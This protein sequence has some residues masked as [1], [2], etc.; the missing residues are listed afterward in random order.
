MERLLPEPDSLFSK[1]LKTMKRNILTILAAAI[2]SCSLACIDTY[3]QYVPTP[4]TISAEKVQYEGKVYYSHVVKERQTLYGISKAYGVSIEEIYAAN[5]GLEQLGLQKDSYIRI[6]CNEASDNAVK[7]A[8]E[9]AATQIQETA[10]SVPEPTVTATIE[11][12]APKKGVTTHKVKWYEDLDGIAAK[13]GVSAEA[14]MKANGLSSKDL[15][16]KK[17]LIIPS[18]QEAESLTADAAEATEPA[19]D[20]TEEPQIEE[21]YP[22]EETAGYGYERKNSV[23]IRFMLPL[24]SSVGGSE[25]NMDFYCGALLAV[26]DKADEG[27]DVV[28]NTNDVTAGIPEMS[29]SDLA[30]TDVII[31]P[32]SPAQIQTLM[33]KIP[34]DLYVV[35][36]LDPKAESLCGKY[37]NLIQAPTPSSVQRMDVINW[38]KDDMGSHDKAIVFYEKYTKEL[39]DSS[40]INLLLA[41]SGLRHD[42]FSY[43]IL[44]GRNIQT[45]LSQLMTKEGVNRIIIASEKEAFVNDV[46]R[47][48]NLMIFNQ[49]Q[50]ML[51]SPA[52]IRGFETIEVDNL[53]NANLHVSAT[54]NVDYD[55]PRVQSFLMRYRALYG[56]EPTAFAFQG[57]DLSYY[58]ISLVSKWGD[59]WE[60]MICNDGRSSMLQEDFDFRRAP[61][62]G[63]CINRAVRHFI[64]G[65]DYSIKP[66]AK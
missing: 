54:Y 27:I 63:A 52:K 32:V 18:A 25:S 65:D 38:V 41:Q 66:A 28:V 34:E 45:A 8:T 9:T 33:A 62:G 46:V 51:Y 7:A 50:V 1:A 5:P 17:K 19:K 55:D 47:N 35:S 30:S 64:Y 13:Y 11:T 48:L 22:Q 24:K 59:N 61:D 43:S 37:H 26:K 14:I 12:P 23:N 15:S 3:A 44:E 40:S 42:K 58:F 29:S 31:G 56:T 10:Q 4:V 2:V 21:Q 6:P 49:Y 16:S 20:E 39:Q 60:E 53:H 57:Y 36:P